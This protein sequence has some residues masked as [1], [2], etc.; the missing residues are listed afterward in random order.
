MDRALVRLAASL[1]LGVSM[2]P[3]WAAHSVHSIDAK[4]LDNR[5]EA[6]DPNVLHKLRNALTGVDLPP[7]TTIRLTISHGG[8]VSAV[9]VVNEQADKLTREKARKALS[10]LSF[11]LLPSNPRSGST[12]LVF[13]VGDVLSS[14]TSSVVNQAALPANTAGGEGTSTVVG[15]RDPLV[16]DPKLSGSDASFAEEMNNLYNDYYYL[17]FPSE[18]GRV[19]FSDV[20]Y[21]RTGKDS[22]PSSEEYIH[23]GET[24]AKSNHT[25]PAIMC[26]INAT[27]E[28]VKKGDLDAV[29]PLIERAVTM[30]MK[31]DEQNRRFTRKALLAYVDSATTYSQNE[32]VLANADFILNKVKTIPLEKSEDPVKAQLELIQVQKKLYLKQNRTAEQIELNKKIASQCLLMKPPD[33]KTAMEAYRDIETVAQQLTTTDELREASQKSLNLIEEQLGGGLMELQEL[34][35][36]IAIAESNHHTEES[37]FFRSRLR[38]I[39]DNY[40]PQA[41]TNSG[42]RDHEAVR[43]ADSMLNA[44]VRLNGGRR[45]FNPMFGESFASA[46]AEALDDVQRQC[47]KLKVKAQGFE[48]SAL[49][50]FCN[51]LQT[52]GRDDEAADLLADACRYIEGSS[53]TRIKNQLVNARN[54]LLNVLT[55]AGRADEANAVKEEIAKVHDQ[56]VAE[57]ISREEASIKDLESQASPDYARLAETR[58][59][60]AGAYVRER[61]GVGLR[62]LLVKVISD[63][64]KMHGR[65]EGA[66]SVNHLSGTA[67]QISFHLS[68]LVQEL[69]RKGTIP[70][71]DYEDVLVKAFTTAD[72]QLNGGLDQQRMYVSSLSSN[73]KL[74]AAVMNALIKERQ[75]REGI[76]AASLRPIYES[77]ARNEQRRRE[78]NN[79]LVHEREILAID[80]AHSAERSVIL[81]DQVSLAKACLFV[82]QNSEANKLFESVRK[83]L[84]SEKVDLPTKSSMSTLL[85]DLSHELVTANQ[86]PQADAAVRLAISLMNA[87]ARNGTEFYS[88]SQATSKLVAEYSTSHEQQKA[89]DLLNYVVENLEK[90][91]G[92]ENLSVLQYR[93]SLS[94]V[95][96]SQAKNA[97]DKNKD[98][99]LSKSEDEFNKLIDILKSSALNTAMRTNQ[100]TSYTY[101]RIEALRSNGFEDQ[102]TF[103]EAKLQAEPNSSRHP[104]TPF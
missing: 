42:A 62:P 57:A 2:A 47:Y 95:Y 54:S 49:S 33:F 101:M 26:F 17:Q 27:I 99:L 46:H 88:I 35:H 19:I 32:K 10:G 91:E 12:N 28:P 72:R 81:Q 74:E 22:M 45:T 83:T 39:V 29:R 34:G 84:S 7:S 38:E 13:E 44:I 79:Y 60:L 23:Q 5:I 70:A 76:H 50:N 18:N 3:A 71:S 51:F 40:V 103:L 80:Q 65:L 43:E 21:P 24:F 75:E 15:H 30:A 36:L 1:L 9:E 6:L 78:Y 37:E 53:D 16:H 14:Q 85:A 58:L 98:A 77:L 86:I 68:Y 52:E 96:L 92:K 64:E 82:H 48:F 90:I 8:K 94:D 11:G 97:G 41:R 20:Y 66:V 31:G 25:N 104:I 59:R 73:G 67:N 87:A 89:V 93:Y 61:N 4:A 56:E 55:R 102:A 100:I 69:S 63:L